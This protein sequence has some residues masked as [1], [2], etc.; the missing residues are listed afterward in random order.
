MSDKKYPV[1]MTFEGSNVNLPSHGLSTANF[2]L[3]LLG[4]TGTWAALSGRSRGTQ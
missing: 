3:A 1:A 2:A 4:L